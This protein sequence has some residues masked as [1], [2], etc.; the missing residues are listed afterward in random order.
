MAELVRYVKW[1][2]QTRGGGRPRT[3]PFKDV[4]QRAGRPWDT[5]PEIAKGQWRRLPRAALPGI[6]LDDP[7]EEDGRPKSKV[8]RELPQREGMW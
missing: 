7:W 8:L 5:G 2:G 3:R 6:D 4:V 1:A